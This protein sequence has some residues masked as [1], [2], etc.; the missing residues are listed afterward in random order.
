MKNRKKILKEPA[1]RER[2]ALAAG[3]DKRLQAIIGNRDEAAVGKMLREG[4]K[5]ALLREFAAYLDRRSWFSWDPKGAVT[6]KAF[7]YAFPVFSLLDEE[8]LLTAAL[9]AE[10]DPAE[11]AAISKIDR[12]SGLDGGIVHDR[13]CKTM[14]RGDLVY[15]RRFGKEL[16]LRDKALFFETLARFALTGRIKSLKALWVVAMINFPADFDRKG[17]FDDALFHLSLSYPVKYRDD[18]YDPG[19]LTDG[20]FSPRELWEKTAGDGDLPPRGRLALAAYLLLVKR[21]VPD[22]AA[23]L[24]IANFEYD[25]ICRS[26]GNKEDENPFVAPLFEKITKLWEESP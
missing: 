14:A 26:I 6:R 16:Y 12:L 20:R 19:E 1:F 13:F 4:G 21:Y 8:K 3:R 24:R 15:A 2:A 18:F 5:T 22:E 25:N 7:H 9:F 17:D 23:F 11:K 10:A